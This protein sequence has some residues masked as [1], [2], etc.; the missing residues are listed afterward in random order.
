MFFSHVPGVTQRKTKVVISKV[1]NFL[2]TVYSLQKMHPQEGQPFSICSLVNQNVK[3]VSLTIIRGGEDEFQFVWCMRAKH[4]EYYF[5]VKA[6]SRW[7]QANWNTG[8]IVKDATDM[9]LLA[10]RLDFKQ[11]PNT[12]EA[13]MCQTGIIFELCLEPHT[14]KLA[15]KKYK[16]VTGRSA[17]VPRNCETS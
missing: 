16:R 1:F 12:K 7:K 17:P 14:K 13:S 3:G 2:D 8:E 4:L 11:T 5:P 10:G 6:I 15:W 9:V